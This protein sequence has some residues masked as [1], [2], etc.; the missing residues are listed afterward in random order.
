MTHVAGEKFIQPVEQDDEVEASALSGQVRS[1]FSLVH[2]SAQ[3]VHGPIGNGGPTL[4][5]TTLDGD[6][7][8]K[9]GG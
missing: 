2:Q 8:L 9:R 6:I 3:N 1:E 5:L 7:R 4:K